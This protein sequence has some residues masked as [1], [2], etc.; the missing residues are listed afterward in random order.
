MIIIISEKI[1][2]SAIIT[3]IDVCASTWTSW[4]FD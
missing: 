3:H 2:H 1:T 4:N